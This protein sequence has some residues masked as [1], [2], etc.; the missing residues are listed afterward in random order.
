MNNLRLRNSFPR[1][2]A[3]KGFQS[4][5]QLTRIEFEKIVLFYG[6]NSA[7]KSAILDA[8]ELIH[9]LFQKPEADE[10]LSKLRAWR[11][12]DPKTQRLVDEFL[13]ETEID[14]V[15]NTWDQL[16]DLNGSS[17]FRGL[18]DWI[19]WY[20]EDGEHVSRRIGVAFFARDAK[21]SFG[22]GLAV[23]F[24]VEEQFLVESD[25]R[26]DI[27]RL[28]LRNPLLEANGD[29][30]ELRE[31]INELVKT[32][33]GAGSR[34]FTVDEHGVLELRLSGKNDAGDDLVEGIPFDDFFLDV[35]ELLGAFDG[36]ELELARIVSYFIRFFF[37]SV[38]GHFLRMADFHREP[39]ARIPPL[40]RDL[41][42]ISQEELGDDNGYLESRIPIRTD[43]LP[44]RD[45]A[46]DIFRSKVRSEFERLAGVDER[47]GQPI[48]VSGR[49][50]LEPP[51][52][53][54][55]IGDWTNRVLAEYL[56][57]ENGYRVD[58]RF[59]DASWVASLAD[60]L[61]FLR[62]PKDVLK[63]LFYRPVIL[64]PFLVDQFGREHEFIDVGSGLTQILPFLIG[65]HL[66]RTAAI[67][68][69][70][71]HLHPAAQAVL[72]DVFIEM[73]HRKCRLIVETHS[74]HLLLR[75]LRRIRNTA[76][77]KLSDPRLELLAGDVAVYYF[78]PLPSGE[79]VVKRL[80]IAHDG[81]FVDRWPRGFFAERDEDLLDE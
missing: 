54:E 3:L 73:L 11:R 74:E 45:L 52:E 32:V 69:P 76:S 79:T 67:Q 44:Y 43:L 20:R 41:V 8:F 16:E 65:A 77:G 37:V 39:S 51:R 25:P 55:S 30:C 33:V 6:P 4:F 68:Q 72:G 5:A 34:F 56:F 40:P 38:G 66:R 26:G 27:V 48:P 60:R 70:E 61:E 14:T 18:W 58:V 75:L 80:R 29:L 1:Y 49:E 63:D 21:F 42:F 59:V 19:W 28:N 12:V 35:R 36:P 47:S 9:D 7:G 53:E 64:R 10:T 50:T 71:L 22:C 15:W 13:L 46:A 81:V 2:L 23:R 17:L 24:V 31:R 62:S 57:L 78:D